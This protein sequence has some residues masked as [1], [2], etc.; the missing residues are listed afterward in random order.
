MKVAG[1]CHATAGNSVYLLETQCC[2]PEVQERLMKKGGLWH[3]N[4]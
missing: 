3:K 2:R 1:V 4:N